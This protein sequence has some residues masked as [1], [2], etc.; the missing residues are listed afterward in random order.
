MSLGAPLDLLITRQLNVA[1]FV[2]DKYAP[3]Y[4]RWLLD[5]I[6]ENH[7]KKSFKLDPSW[8]LSPAPSLASHQPTISD[9]LVDSLWAGDITSVYGLRRFIAG[10]KVELDDGT[11]LEVDAV[12]LCTGYKPDFSITP[13]FSPLEQGAGKEAGIK[14]APLARLY[15]NI[16][17][18]Q[19]ADSLA[20]MN[21]AAIT[22]GGNLIGTELMAVAIA[23]IWK[24]GFALPSEDE[25]NVEIDQHHK[26]IRSLGTN[27]SVYTGIVRPGPWL[28]FLDRAADSGVEKNLGY[29]WEGWKFWMR[30]RKLSGLMM[31]G[32]QTP[33]MY[34]L[35]EGRRKKWDGARDAILHSNEI[36]KIYRG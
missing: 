19:Y 23:Q 7:S 28:A 8:R 24:G 15:Q 17:P 35:F 12:V 31:R 32:V 26:W 10:N 16:F 27:D 13:D 11:I 9:T 29:G 21:Y 36:A 6:S 22:G 34:R 4:G 2:L 3:S 20:Y 18:P 33:F 30:D 5:W 25:M 14:R 1:R